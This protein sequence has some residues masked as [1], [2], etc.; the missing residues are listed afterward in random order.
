MVPDYESDTDNECEL[1]YGALPDEESRSNDLHVSS[2]I[3]VLD[4]ISGLDRL[5]RYDKAC[6]AATGAASRFVRLLP[7]VGKR[8]RMALL[9]AAV[10]TAQKVMAFVRW[11]RRRATNT[12]RIIAAGLR[13]TNNGVQ[14]A[15]FNLI[16]KSEQNNLSRVDR[17]D[18]PAVAMQQCLL[19][20][21]YPADGLDDE[22]VEGLCL[23]MTLG[24]TMPAATGVH[25]CDEEL[26]KALEKSGE[27]AKFKYLATRMA[28]KGSVK[29]GSEIWK[30]YT[31]T[32]H[33]A[34]HYRNWWGSVRHRRKR[35]VASIDPFD[36]KMPCKSREVLFTM[37][38]I[39]SAIAPDCF[40][41][42]KPDQ[43]HR[44]IVLDLLRNL[45][46]QVSQGGAYVAAGWAADIV[47]ALLDR[48]GF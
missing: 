31:T 38:F 39:A 3:N 8:L 29:H 43:A 20:H 32:D 5:I 41:R 47:C 42:Y 46:N 4:W 7:V 21:G 28:L 14:Q 34:G 33:Y 36:P 15:A 1:L 2:I 18:R 30:E 48:P 37:L 27:Y 16:P 35:H 40:S 9:M 44:K 26:V 6:L 23:R 17:D 12:Q 19:R 13:F 24:R 10:D 22:A 25:D 45:Q 11:R